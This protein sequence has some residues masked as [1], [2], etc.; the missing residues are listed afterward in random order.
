MSVL[1]YNFYLDNNY[2]ET[3][4]SIAMTIY[5]V[6]GLCGSVGL[7]IFSTKIHVNRFYLH[8][9]GT[10]VLAASQLAF[11]LVS[12]DDRI[13]TPMIGLFGFG[14]SV[15]CANLGSV[16]EHINGTRLLYLV[17]GYE[18]CAAGIGSFIGPV[19]GAALQAR[20]GLKAPFYFG[21]ACC[22]ASIVLY[23]LYAI[24]NRDICTSVKKNAQKTSS[25]S[26]LEPATQSI[27]TSQISLAVP[28]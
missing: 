16:I 28:I 4:A 2:S 20:F 22:L 15:V 5:G 27:T 10:L 18:M 24:F 7:G 14:Y 3:S 8:L 11:P 17:Y 21:S 26:H 19:A 9:V 25:A 1:A 23:V 13:M 12:F 6:G